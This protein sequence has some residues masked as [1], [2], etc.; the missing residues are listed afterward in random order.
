MSVHYILLL[1][2]CLWRSG[3]QEH[4]RMS[5]QECYACSKPGY[6]ARECPQGD[7]RSGGYRG[8]DPYG[9]GGGF[10]GGSYRS[11]T[12][13]FGSRGGRHDGRGGGKEMRAGP[14][15]KRD[16]RGTSY[17]HR[18]HGQSLP[19]AV[20]FP[21][22]TLWPACCHPREVSTLLSISSEVSKRVPCIP[23]PYTI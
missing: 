16:F 14:T 11:G 7:Q 5:A 3:H 18:Q 10:F 12:G 6:F 4:D 20:S 8:R 1:W 21:S 13:G 19:C 15:R 23:F 2:S 22:G 9:G 17:A